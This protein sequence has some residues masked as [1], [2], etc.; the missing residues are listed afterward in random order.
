MIT[1]GLLHELFEYKDGN[2]IRKVA[3]CNKVRVG[4]VVGHVANHGYKVVSI[5]NKPRLLHRMI[6]LYHRGYLPEY[7]DHIDRNI[8]NN[9]IENLRD[10]SKSENCLNRQQ[11]GK[12]T[13]SGY[14]G[15][16][17]CY[18]GWQVRITEGGVRKNLGWYKTLD[19][20]LSVRFG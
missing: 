11:I 2:L 9:N 4:D 5:L 1:Q 10:I 17:K 20:A 14:N 19:E 15:I 6:Y 3:P 12:D 16:T 7:V 8:L 18:N 13:M